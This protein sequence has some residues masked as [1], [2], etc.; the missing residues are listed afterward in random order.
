[1]HEPDNA[2]LLRRY[3]ANGSEEA[4]AA[5]VARHVNL[6]YSVALRRVGNPHQAQE[7][8]H[9]VFVIL[10]KKA[11]SLRPDTILPGWLHKTTS[12]T[13]DNFLKVEFRRKSRE[14]ETYRQSLI[15]EPEVDPWAQVAPLLDVALARLNDADRNAILLRFFSGAALNDVGSALGISEEAAKKRVNRAVEKL[16]RF[17][18]RQGLAMPALTLTAAISAHSVQAAPAGLAVSAAST[19]AGG[20][21]LTLLKATLNQMLYANLKAPVR[22]ALSFSW[23]P[24]SPR[25]LSTTHLRPRLTR[26]SE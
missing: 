3:V 15:N 16:R 8:T 4:F 25:P 11:R 1:M 14:Q 24:A 13:V 20:S 7:I 17:F 9:V 6:V 26:S 21:M 18:A 10:A 2:E 19:T 23:L 22:P 12:F 5:L